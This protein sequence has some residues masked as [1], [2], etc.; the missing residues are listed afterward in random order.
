[1]NLC[2]LQLRTNPA[3]HVTIPES[4]RLKKYFQLVN[5]WQRFLSATASVQNTLEIVAKFMVAVLAFL[6]SNFAEGLNELYSPN[7]IGTT[8]SSLRKRT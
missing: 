4:K 6:K 1:M 3:R 7:C 2:D 8:V 5:S